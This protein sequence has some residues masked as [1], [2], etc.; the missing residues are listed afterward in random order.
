VRAVAVA[1]VSD[2]TLYS[3]PRVGREALRTSPLR[4]GGLTVVNQIIEDKL[5]QPV[6]VMLASL[7]QGD[8]L[9]DDDFR[10]RVVNVT[11]EQE[12]VTGASGGPDGNADQASSSHP[13][14]R[15]A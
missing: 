1:C 8:D 4:S 6:R 15:R 9:V 7:R 5:G 10:H 3:V 14:R 12:R 11:L 13:F 2:F